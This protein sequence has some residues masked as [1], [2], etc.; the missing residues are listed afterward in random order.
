MF[1]G[2]PITGAENYR[3]LGIG[4]FDSPMHPITLAVLREHLSRLW[5]PATPPPQP[6]SPPIP[7][8]QPSKVQPAS[9]LVS[10]HDVGEI[11]VSGD[12][13]P[14]FHAVLLPPRPIER[15]P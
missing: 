11:I 10:D 8:P 9:L 12:D 14:H 3:I 1:R 4:H 15:K 7:A 6:A 13:P 5:L 2:G